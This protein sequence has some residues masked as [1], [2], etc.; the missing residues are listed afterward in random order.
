MRKSVFFTLLLM[1][2]SI[3]VK[4][5]APSNTPKLPVAANK[6]SRNVVKSSKDAH[7]SENTLQ[8]TAATKKI[9]GSPKSTQKQA[10]EKLDKSKELKKQ[11]EAEQDHEKK[12]ALLK[13]AEEESIAAQRFADA[14]RRKRKKARM[15]QIGLVTAG[16]GLSIGAALASDTIKDLI[17]PPATPVASPV[18]T[19]VANSDA[20]ASG[21]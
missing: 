14:A 21:S 11:A 8:K 20:K 9:P 3:T 6:S 13:E 19:P 16:A 12:A 15:G 1:L 7:S 4:I 17:N 5:H 2:L 10:D 18:A